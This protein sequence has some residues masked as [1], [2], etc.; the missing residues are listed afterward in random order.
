MNHDNP[1][2]FLIDT[3]FDIY[4]AIVLLRFLLQQVGADFYNP[5]SQFIVKATHKPV[6]IARRII[7]SLRGIDLATL[8]LAVLLILTKLIILLALGGMQP[9]ISALLIKSLF[10]LISLTFDI[11][12]FAVFLQAILSWVNPDPYNPVSAL[13]S[14]L[15]RP[16]LNPIRKRLPI[17]GGLDLST[18]VA[19]I[20]LMFVKRLVL[21]IF[22][23]F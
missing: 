8:S 14:S 9:S 18:I 2:I 10:D 22:T 12:I 17:M 21:Y 4:I 1:F 6:I 3:L 20:G 15:T 7:P 19:L 23:L 11:F 16:I 5:I 13:L